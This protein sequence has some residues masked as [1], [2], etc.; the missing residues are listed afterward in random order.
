MKN[1]ISTIILLMLCAWFSGLLFAR[2]K[3]ESKV[4]FSLRIFTS[5]NLTGNLEPCG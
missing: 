4:D 1:K 5:V 3:I 2:D